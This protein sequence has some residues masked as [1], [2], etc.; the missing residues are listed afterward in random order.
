MSHCNRCT[1]ILNIEN[2][3]GT[4]IPE[5]RPYIYT[6][7]RN[8]TDQPMA[9]D[10]MMAGF[11]GEIERSPAVYQN[12]RSQHFRGHPSPGNS[13]SRPLVIINRE[14]FGQTSNGLRSV[15]IWIMEHE[16]GANSGTVFSNELRSTQHHRTPM[17]GQHSECKA[18]ADMW[19]LSYQF[20]WPDGNSD[21]NGVLERKIT[22][23][24]QVDRM[25]YI[26]LEQLTTLIIITNMKTQSITRYYRMLISRL[27]LK[28]CI[29]MLNKLCEKN[30]DEHL[31]KGFVYFLFG[32]TVLYYYL[33][34][35]FSC[36]KQPVTIKISFMND[37]G[38]RNFV[39][40]IRHSVFN[41]ILISI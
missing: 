18:P 8:S 31:E 10:E 21:T 25:V 26:S 23:T 3:Y 4:A 37:I 1:H 38:T 41:R 22:T 19:Y 17:F 15:D 20:S 29:A 12:V 27:M 2:R 6:Y 39:F 14:D 34:T 24:Q 30:R 35:G 32:R 5:R 7:I 40:R 28:E 33:L 11:W 16:G 9:T 36:S 13:Y